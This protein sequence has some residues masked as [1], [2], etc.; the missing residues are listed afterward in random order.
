MVTSP[1]Y[2]GKLLVEVTIM[3]IIDPVCHRDID[4]VEYPEQEEYE[5]TIYFFCSIEHAQEF[6][7]HSEKYADPSLGEK[8]PDYTQR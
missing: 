7:L 6:R 2:F 5:D 1:L 8:I 3:S 4:D